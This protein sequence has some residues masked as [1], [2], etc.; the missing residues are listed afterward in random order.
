MSSINYQCLPERIEL[1]E[2]CSAG[3]DSICLLSSSLRYYSISI[4]GLSIKHCVNLLS[5]YPWNTRLRPGL[6]LEVGVIVLCSWAK[7]LTLAVPLST[8]VYKWVL[9]N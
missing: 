1:R 7:Y 8:Q 5:I 4:F 2:K 9:D 3:S 6:R